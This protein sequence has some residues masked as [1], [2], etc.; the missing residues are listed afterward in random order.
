[1]VMLP[2]FVVA[3]GMLV[4]SWWREPRRLRNGALLVLAV[5]FGLLAGALEAPDPVDEIFIA[6]ILVG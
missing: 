1:M 6:A 5:L 4:V 3:L 2:L